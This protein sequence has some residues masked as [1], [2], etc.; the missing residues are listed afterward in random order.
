M[1]EPTLWYAKALAEPEG[2]VGFELDTAYPT[3]ARAL[4]K[5]K[6]VVPPTTQD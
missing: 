2:V 6:V 4:E 1:F 3:V 5:S